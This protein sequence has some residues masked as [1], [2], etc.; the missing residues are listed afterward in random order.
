[1]FSCSIVPMDAGTGR[2][3]FLKELKAVPEDACKVFV[4]LYRRD[5]KPKPWVAEGYVYVIH[6]PGNT[7]GVVVRRFQ[8]EEYSDFGQRTDPRYIVWTGSFDEIVRMYSKPRKRR[9]LANGLLMF[10]AKDGVAK[11]GEKFVE[12]NELLEAMR[13]TQFPEELVSVVS[14]GTNP[15]A[16]LFGLSKVTKEGY[17]QPSLFEF[18]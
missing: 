4:F 12:T 5:F 16:S 13:L 17:R 8:E 10:F 9:T 2:I 14:A 6:L 15:R 11:G 1:M 7:A 18:E 3:Q